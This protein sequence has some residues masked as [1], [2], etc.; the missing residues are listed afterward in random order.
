M[1]N[2]ASVLTEITLTIKQIL[3]DK[4]GNTYSK[5]LNTYQDALSEYNVDSDANVL[6]ERISQTTRTIME[7]PPNDQKLGLQLLEQITQLYA[8]LPD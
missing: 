5:L 7:S 1:D 6:K 4:Y 2:I 8:Y 3:P